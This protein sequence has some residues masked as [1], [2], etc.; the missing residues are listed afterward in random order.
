MK[1]LAKVIYLVASIA[2]FLNSLPT[3]RAQSGAAKIVLSP[4]SIVLTSDQVFTSRGFAITASDNSTIAPEITVTDPDLCSQALLVSSVPH[5]GPAILANIF[6]LA[7]EAPYGGLVCHVGVTDSRLGTAQL[8]VTIVNGEATGPNGEFVVTD[9][10]LSFTPANPASQPLCL[11]NL[12]AATAVT[13]TSTAAVTAGTNWLQVTPASGTVPGGT[14]SCG[15]SA[16]QVQATRGALAPGK[17]NGTVTITPANLGDAPPLVVGVSFT[18]GGNTPLQ[19]ARASLPVG[20]ELDA[21]NFNYQIGKS[22]PPSQTLS[23]LSGGVRP[24]AFSA[25]VYPGSPWLT[26]E[27]NGSALVTPAG[28]TLKL[29]PEALT[30]PAGGYGATINV[31]APEASNPDCVI[32]VALFISQGPL[33]TLGTLPTTFNFQTGGPNPPS[34]TITVTTTGDPVTFNVPS[35]F[36]TPWLSVSPT[37][38]AASATSPQTL[39]MTVNPAGLDPGTYI[40]SVDVSNTIETGQGSSTT[41]NDTVPVTLNVS[42]SP[43]LNYTPSVLIFNFQTPQ[44]PPASQILHLSA[45]ASSLPFAVAASAVCGTEKSDRP[46]AHRFERRPW[47]TVSP[48]RGVTEGT[49]S[50]P[51]TVSVDPAVVTS[52]E[53]CTGLVTITSGGAANAIQ[54]PVTLNAL[55]GQ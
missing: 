1:S 25:T 31:S 14:F 23:I 45:T 49:A 7:V 19:V 22:V 5:Q 30:L 55:M 8:F 3:A 33:V 53:T 11:L 12:G 40:G 10:S 43:L 44:K 6:L 32:F 37:S 38:G 51:I 17:Y 9:A 27:P 39:T 46:H 16:I 24:I 34:Q 54:I 2:V 35:A 26:I 41:Y 36:Q 13:Y 52:E 50:L 20:T 28:V 18:V 42:S 47:F 15:T 29:T 48:N 4:S 21:V